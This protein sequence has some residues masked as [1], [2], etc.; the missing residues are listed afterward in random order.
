MKQQ[1]R[2]IKCN[3][4]KC[5]HEWDYKGKQKFY[6]TCPQCLTKV[7]IEKWQVKKKK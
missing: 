6:A 4:K 7:N 5:G 2:R 3:K 1:V